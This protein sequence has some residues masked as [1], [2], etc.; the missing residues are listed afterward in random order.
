MRNGIPEMALFYPP[1]SPLSVTV[2]AAWGLAGLDCSGLLYEA[3]DGFTPRNSSALVNYGSPLP[4]A[5]MEPAAVAAVLLPLD[6]IVWDGHVMIV[7]DGG[8]VVE[9]RLRCGAPGNGGVVVRPLRR[10]LTR[11]MKARRAVDLYPVVPEKGKKEF[12]VRRWY[13]EPK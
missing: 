10:A 4:L 2:A 7:L 11:L 12:V 13:P 9:S 1:P 3:T 5:G 8:E 6:L